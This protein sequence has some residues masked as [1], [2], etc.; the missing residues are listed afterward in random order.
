MNVIVG[1]V[2]KG[3]ADLAK[4]A[5]ASS[6]K[7]VPPPSLVWVTEDGLIGKSFEWQKA[8]PIRITRN[9]MSEGYVA[10]RQKMMMETEADVYVSLDDDAWFLDSNTIA[11]A[12]RAMEEDS[13]VAVVAF[14]ILS[15]DCP[16]P[17]AKDLPKVAKTFVGCGHAIRLQAV[18]EVGGYEK[19]PGSYGGEE[20][21]LCLRLIERGWKVVKLPGVV[22]WHDKT[23]QLRDLRHQRRAGVLNDLSL[24]WRRCP[25]LKV[26]IYLAGN[27]YHQVTFS[28]KNP[29][30]RFWPSLLGIGDFLLS[31]PAQ[32]NLRRP[33][34]AKSW[35][36][37]R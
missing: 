35:D 1:I 19:F 25:G 6:L 17:S 30:T 29:G 34:S 28:I 14:E 26:W 4:K 15:P 22:V 21:D 33:V 3:R 31:L 13:A 20:K 16:Q 8:D 9:K 36:L 27:I 7:Q 2:T 23:P 5:V 32:W 10:A 24:I 11:E 37:G 12:I 18:R